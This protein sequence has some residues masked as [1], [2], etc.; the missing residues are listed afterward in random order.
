MRAAKSSLAG[1][2][3]FLWF[4]HEK[5]VPCRLY[6]L[7]LERYYSKLSPIIQEVEQLSDDDI[8]EATRDVDDSSDRLI[9]QEFLDALVSLSLGFY[10]RLISVFCDD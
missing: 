9:S 2:S 1:T 5:G 3:L 4:T 6:L 10:V 7:Q 8:Y